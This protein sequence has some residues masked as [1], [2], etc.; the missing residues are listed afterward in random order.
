VDNKKFKINLNGFMETVDGQT[1]IA[2]LVNKHGDGDHHVIVE[3]NG[4]YIYPK[5]YGT[6]LVEMGD[7]IEI[8][9][10]DFGG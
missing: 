4:R 8:V 2:Q 3:R 10:P 5:E 9:H 1:T 6:I 7:E